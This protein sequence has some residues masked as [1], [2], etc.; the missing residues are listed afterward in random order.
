MKIAVLSD[1]HG[2]LPALESTLS[3][4]YKENINQIIFLGD[5]IT[6]FAQYTNEV[7]RIVRS[8]SLNVIR[9]NR[10]GYLIHQSNNP[11]DDTWDKYKQFSTN[12]NTF[13]HLSKDDIS[14]IS[15]LPQQLTFAFDNNFYVRAVHGSPF[16]EFDTIYSDNIELINRSLNEIEEN[17]LLCG[18]THRPFIHSVG[19]KTLI[20]VG[21]VGLNFDREQCAHY[22]VIQYENGDVKINMKK[23]KYDY[24][25]FKRSCD[26]NDPWVRLCLKSMEDGVNY[27]MR[28]LEEAKKCCGTW[29]IPNEIYNNLFHDWCGRGIV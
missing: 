19:E 18:H 25:A 16:S 17:I 14:Y 3:E 23:A 6:D 11:N 22:T 21:S 4:I 12:K 29:P 5:L 13:E 10:E 9:G 24:D 28:F 8:T 2:N 20:N 1:I 27:N 26:L 15:A 7:L